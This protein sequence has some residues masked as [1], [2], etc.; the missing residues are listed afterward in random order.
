M[1]K[2]KK[3]FTGSAYV[4]F[5][6]NAALSVQYTKANLRQAVALDNFLYVAQNHVLKMVEVG[7]LLCHVSCFC[8]SA[9]LSGVITEVADHGVLVSLS[10]SVRGLVPM[11][12]LSKDDGVRQEF[13]KFFRRGMGVRAVVRSVDGGRRRLILSLAGKLLLYISCYILLGLRYLG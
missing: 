9:S 1:V 2:P 12:H 4:L 8:P 7:L 6:T 13:R 11:A 3:A 5:I 10:T